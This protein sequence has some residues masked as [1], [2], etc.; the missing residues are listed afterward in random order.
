MDT[1]PLL[2]EGAS[3]EDVTTEFLT[4]MMDVA[5]KHGLSIDGISV[6]HSEA[7]DDR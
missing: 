7:D 2:I 1:L 5:D 4:D 3:P 6:R